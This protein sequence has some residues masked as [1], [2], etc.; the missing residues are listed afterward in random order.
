MRQDTSYCHIRKSSFLVSFMWYEEFVLKITSWFT[1][2][3]NELFTVYVLSSYEWN[4]FPSWWK[5]PFWLLQFDMYI[6][7]IHVCC[8]DCFN[9]RGKCRISPY[10]LRLASQKIQFFL[11]SD[12]TIILLFT[13]TISNAFLYQSLQVSWTAH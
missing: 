11:T 8:S 12:I 10:S 1:N 9:G 7:S 2:D 13:S 5:L 4:L 3:S 6:H